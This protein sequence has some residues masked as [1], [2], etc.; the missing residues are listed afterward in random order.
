MNGPLS[1]YSLK[2]LVYFTNPVDLTPTMYGMKNIYWRSNFNYRGENSLQDSLPNVLE[3]GSTSEVEDL[4]KRQE[5][6]L[7]QL[8]FLKEQMLFLR[9]ELTKGATNVKLSVESNCNLTVSSSHL[10]TTNNPHWDGLAGEMVI[11]ASPDNPPYSLLAVNR[12][13]PEALRLQVVCHTHSSLVS[14]SPHLSCFSSLFFTPGPNVKARLIWSNMGPDCEL[15]V[16]PISHCPIRGEVNVLRFL[17]RS[18]NGSGDPISDTQL[19]HILDVCHRLT[20]AQSQRDRQVNVRMLNSLLGRSS[21]LGGEKVS[22]ADVA[23]WSAI[24]RSPG[25]DLSQNM[26]RWNDQCTQ[27]FLVDAA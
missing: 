20:H 27:A 9:E 18:I 14:L 25:I 8:A 1:M 10:R 4:K 22:V 11:N 26:A 23:A 3:Q 5:E 21:W 19:D 17:H 13:W 16:S 12:L 7:K 24:K 2:P 6:I 15:V